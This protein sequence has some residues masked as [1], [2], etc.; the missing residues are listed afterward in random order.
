MSAE[1]IGG[2]CLLVDMGNQRLKWRFL[3]A[4]VGSRYAAAG[5]D[6]VVSIPRAGSESSTNPRAAFIQV[7]DTSFSGPDSPHRPAPRRVLLSAVSHGDTVSLFERWCLE[8]WQ[9]SVELMISAD[10]YAGLVN[11]YDNPRQLGCDR[12][13]AALAAFQD[14]C[15]DKGEESVIVVDAGTA[16]TVDLVHRG[17][18]AGGAILPGIATIIN[19]LGRD[20]GRIRLDPSWFRN[21][22]IAGAP[23]AGDVPAAA[24]NS[25]AAVHAGAFHAVCGGVERCLERLQGM[26]G[27]T[28]RILVSGGDA[29]L[30]QGGIRHHAEI[31]RNLVLDGLALVAAEMAA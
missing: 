1:R 25:N 5:D 23:G 18:F 30:V 3:P 29:R 4:G 9:V 28:A 26:V 16:V 12:W 8:R 14:I 21:R 11:G 2:D 20:T 17:R 6:R 24:T 27:G 15:V 7:L 22:V 19:V 10:S 31:R 13:L